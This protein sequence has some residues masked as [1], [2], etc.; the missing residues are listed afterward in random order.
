M[1][2]K[3]IL[4][5][6]IFILPF[7]GFGPIGITVGS[8][9]ASIGAGAIGFRF[10]GKIGAVFALIFCKYCVEVFIIY[11]TYLIYFNSISI[12]FLKF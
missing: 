6:G 7:M 11:I 5:F 12:F 1:H 4:I 8:F 9:A 3:L 2:P 10:Y